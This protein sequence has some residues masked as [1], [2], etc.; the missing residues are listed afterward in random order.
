[1]FDTDVGKPAC[2]NTGQ[3]EECFFLARNQPIHV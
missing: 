2:T 1:M 3:R